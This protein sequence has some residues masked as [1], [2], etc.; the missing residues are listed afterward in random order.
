M[1]RCYYFIAILL[2]AGS[3]ARA[4]Q[5][6][7]EAGKQKIT[8]RRTN[9]PVVIDGVFSPGEWSAAIPVHVDAV[10]PS[11]AP[12]VVPWQGLPYAINPPDNQ[13][14]SSFSIY[15]MYDDENLYV[16]VDVADDKVIADNPDFPWLDDDVEIFINGDRQPFDMDAIRD[17]PDW[18]GV[19]PNNEGF[20]LVTSAGNVR[21]VYPSPLIQVDWDSKVGLRPRGYLFEAR[22]SLDSINT[23]D[24]SWFTNPNAVPPDDND[25]TLPAVPGAVFSP[26]FRRPHPGDSIG[27]NISVSDDDNGRAGDDPLNDSYLRTD[28][29][30][31]PSSYTAWDG[32]S[33]N[34][35]YADEDAWGTLYF[36]P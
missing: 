1:K 31:N 21:A 15:T 32:S 25:P 36:A 5:Q 26:A 9:K 20:Q 10:H 19:L 30:R 27:F 6:T 16:A 24:N 17:I 7:T 14:D 23:I 22:I 18:F 34:W 4:D 8:A 28:L 35:Y 3:S 33:P 29:A 11:T 2:V 12:G 13:D